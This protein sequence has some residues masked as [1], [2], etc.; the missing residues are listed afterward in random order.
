MPK[1]M[2]T[3]EYGTNSIDNLSTGQHK[4]ILIHEQ[5][6]VEIAEVSFPDILCS[7]KKV[8]LK[9]TICSLWIYNQYT[10]QSKIV[11]NCSFLHGVCPNF[12]EYFNVIFGIE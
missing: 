9:Y 11:P 5:I 12:S 8:S 10:G 7:F 4:I 6:F 2:K 1:N 3:T